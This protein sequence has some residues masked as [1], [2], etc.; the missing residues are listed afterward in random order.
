MEQDIVDPGSLGYFN[1]FQGGYYINPFH[2]HSEEYAD[3]KNGFDA[4][5]DYLKSKIDKEIINAN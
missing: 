3:F 2:K 4:G 1:G 5:R